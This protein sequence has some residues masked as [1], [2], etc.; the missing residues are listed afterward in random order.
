MPKSQSCNDLNFRV[1]QKEVGKNC[2]ITFLLLVTFGHFFGRFCRFFCHFFARL[3]LQQGNKLQIAQFEIAE[4][5]RNRP[6]KLVE[7]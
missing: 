4:P 2:S 5:Q 6:P 7:K 3:L 1:P